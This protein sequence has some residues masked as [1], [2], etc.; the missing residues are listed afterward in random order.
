MVPGTERLCVA[1]IFRLLATLHA[2]LVNALVFVAHGTITSLQH[3]DESC[4]V[5]NCY[6]VVDGCME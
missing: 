2:F 5:A 6:A 4:P 3:W 1:S